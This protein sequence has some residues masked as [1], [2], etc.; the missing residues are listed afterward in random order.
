MCQHARGIHVATTQ[1]FT[2]ETIEDVLVQ[3][4]TALGDDAVILSTNETTSGGMSGFFG[5]RTIIV[6]AQASRESAVASGGGAEV[7]L[8]ALDG[9]Q[10]ALPAPGVDASDPVAFSQ[11]LARQ[12]DQARVVD[13]PSAP[14]PP[15]AA[16][17]AP[18]ASPLAAYQSAAPGELPAAAPVAPPV[19]APVGEDAILRQQE[20]ARLAE[21]VLAQRSRAGAGGFD[22]DMVITPVEALPE[23]PV[24]AAVADPFGLTLPPAPSAALDP[25]V[26]PA[27]TP[28]SGEAPAEVPAEEPSEAPVT[29]PVPSQTARRLDG[30]LAQAQELSSMDVAPAIDALW[31][32]VRRAGVSESHVLMMRH[33]FAVRGATF[34]IDQG[35]RRALREWI[36]EGAPVVRGLDL[37]TARTIAL[38]GQTGVGKST[39]AC[40]LAGR[41]QAAGR[42]IGLIAAGRGPHAVLEIYAREMGLAVMFAETPEELAGV[43]AELMDRD[44]VIIDTAG[45]SHRHADALDELRAMLAAVQ[46]DET[47]LVTTLASGPD[48]VRALAEAFGPAG[49]DRLILTKLDE[50][51]RPGNL[52]NTPLAAGIPL[53]YLADGVSVPDAI[54]PATGMEVAELLLPTRKRG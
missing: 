48:D 39:S 14:P 29:D 33:S 40:K 51:D 53:G 45:R 23:P 30:A 13:G 8:D 17:A 26:A 28:Y 12:L 27:E 6:T 47:Y 46:V 37:G 16:L 10:V 31:S 36:A 15:A 49:A 38:V 20:L 43:H 9:T 24:D 4:R 44:L 34:A 11:M 19:V 22:A 32:E 1:T 2:G 50:A 25:V 21:E 35:P 42:T 5:K 52:I 41:Y 18:P 3:V 7:R 54:F